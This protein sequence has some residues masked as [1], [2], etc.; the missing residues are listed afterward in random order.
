MI[1]KDRLV[2][3][4]VKYVKVSSE[5]RN[6][7]EFY[8]LL[9][10]EL[11]ELGLEVKTDKAGEKINSNGN[12]IYCCIEATNGSDKSRIYSAH[13]DTVKPG[14]DIKPVV[15]KE[16]IKSS[17]DTILGADDKAGI[18]AIMEAVTSIIENS[19]EHNQIEI[20]FTISEEGGLNG[21][22]NLDYSTIKSK[23]AYIFDSG[24]KTGTIVKQAPSQYKFTFEV[25]GEAAHAGGAPEKGISSI[26]VAAEAISNMKLL[27]VDEETTA[28]IGSFI[29]EGET[30][31]VNPKAIV[32]AEARSLSNEKL[33]K[34]AKHM[35]D[36][37]KNTAEK[38]GATVN[39]EK[40]HLYSAFTIDNEE[41]IIK[42]VEK[43]MKDLNLEVVKQS[44]GG[45]SDANIFNVNGIKS[46]NLGMGCMNAHTLKESL[47]IED[48]YNIT[49]VAMKL[50]VE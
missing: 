33:E 38:Y 26:N 6:E 7:K 16:I 43:I 44:S 19:I 14:I 5:T 28:N 15:E 22:K 2:D 20:I 10:K 18:A 21:S 13:M 9:I 37:F 1:N 50:M 27:R 48:L 45:G 46:I 42:N 11:E 29:S 3:R 32:K 31:I 12:N 35:I 24:G 30:N 23:E 40:S 4:F 47:K 17:G 41:D 25:I 8:E 49:Q 34:Q 36:T 39:I